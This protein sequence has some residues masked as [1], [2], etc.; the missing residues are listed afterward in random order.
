MSLRLA[1][2]TLANTPQ[3]TAVALIV[4]AVGLGANAAIFTVVNAVLIRPLPFPNADRL[5]L[6]STTRAQNDRVPLPF[7]L[8]EYRDVRDQAT[9]FDGLA[10]WVYGRGNV[11]ADNPEQAQYAVVTANLLSIL[12]AR[13]ALGRDFAPD[14]DRAGAPPVALISQGLWHRRF[15][16][17]PKAVGN[18]LSLDGRLYTVVGVLGPSFRFL[19]AHYD[20]DIWLPVGSDP[21]LD[22]PNARGLRSAGV[23]GRLKPATTLQ[24]TQIEMNTIAARL[25]T[26][27]PG[28]NRG[29]GMTVMSFREQVVGTLRPAILVLL[30]AV[31]FVL[32]IACAN[33]ANL[34]LAR[35]TARRRELA[36]RS[37]LGAGR[38][39]LVRQLLVENLVLG[40]GGGLL[41]LLVATIGIALLA[42]L[43]GG[44]PSLWSPYAI[45][46]HE[47]GIDRTVVLFTLGLSLA[48]VVLFGLT[49]AM[50]A[51]RV[52]LAESLKDGGSATAARRAGRARTA[53]VVV[54]IA[55]S[56]VLLVGAGLL[57]RTLVHLGRVDLGFDPQQVLSFDVSL[58]AAKY[59]GTAT[60]AF[61]DELIT[62]LRTHAGVTSAA[63][64]EYL[65]FS[66]ADSATG[67]FVDGRAPAAPGNDLRTHYRSVTS[68]YF[69]TMGMTLRSGRG[70]GDRD[71][72]DAPAVAVINETMARRYWPNENAIGQ[73]MAITLEAL[74]FRRD[75]PP[76]LDVP[77]A[78]REIV[79]VVADVKH[80]GVQVDAFPEVYVPFAQRPVRAMTIVVRTAGD[81]G[82]LAAAARRVTGA[83]DP[84]QPIA[85]V[86]A[87]A[88][89]VATS[90][91]QPRFN[92]LLLSA[93]AAMALLLAIVGVYGVMAYSVSLRRHEIGVRLALG[94][95]PRDIASLLVR[96]GMRSTFA[97]LIVGLGSAVM[98]GRGMTGL[99][100]GVSSTDPLTLTMVALFLLGVAFA[101]CYVPAR[102]AAH[103]DATLVLRA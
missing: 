51:S 68:D 69:G 44:V 24:A 97:G 96:E 28:D 5:V 64:A 80:A 15:G 70:L 100:F 86:S 83:L 92:V 29:R 9:V 82:A 12:G 37:A 39:R 54:E 53:L 87:V 41:G 22:R 8:P 90:I 21:V 78:M 18:L 75:G 30:G 81:L 49:P 34:L 72:A 35:A 25:A 98:I 40:V 42:S 91:A 10:A 93:F 63:A 52:D 62:R 79:G 99:L 95:Q 20:T 84:D 45:A 101:S 67:F 88:D 16:S 11:S 3:F 48:T 27:Y 74:R 14:D 60:R 32:L 76:T 23:I 65:P 43:P 38:G 4:L 58:P 59:S 61:F 94:G 56:A 46:A 50:E 66:G 73:R 19:S 85:R 103:L 57:V 33:V 71:G 6:L 47:I 77:A 17:S 7:S 26:T 55:L 13:P 31:G 2:R 1:F 36:I 89:L 102:R